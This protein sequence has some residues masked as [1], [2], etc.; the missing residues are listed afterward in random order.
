MILPSDSFL[1]NPTL[2]QFF[3]A[4]RK[5]RFIYESDR[6]FE[7]CPAKSGFFSQAELDE[8]EQ[9]F[10]TGDAKVLSID[11]STEE[12]AGM[13]IG[14]LKLI[15]NEE[16]KPEYQMLT[17][18]GE[19]HRKA[20]PRDDFVNCTLLNYLPSNCYLDADSYLENCGD[21]Y[22]SVYDANYEMIKTKPISAKARKDDL[23]CGANSIRVFR[24]DVTGSS[25]AW[26]YGEHPRIESD[27][28]QTNYYKRYSIDHTFGYY[29][30]WPTIEL[31]KDND[32]TFRFVC[33]GEGEE[34]TKMRL[35]N[36]YTKAENGE[37]VPD[38]KL[39]IIGG[40]SW[41]HPTFIYFLYK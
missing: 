14:V 1:T 8:F 25:S 3:T 11:Y 7:V 5:N 34:V 19:L 24:I 4:V 39:Q 40:L 16:Q 15:L 36:V 10:E 17:D 29:D 33:P 20:E 30:Y 37:L 21:S 23:V 38:V 6:T 18:F 31:K 9:Y 41:A 12:R 32:Y 27:M 22:T 13:K 35:D 26:D 2:Y 28:Q